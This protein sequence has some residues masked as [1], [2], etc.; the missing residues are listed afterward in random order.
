MCEPREMKI[1]MYEPLEIL[2]PRTKLDLILDKNV[3]RFREFAKMINS[4]NL[5]N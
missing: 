3:H 4:A 2:F 5:R 1:F